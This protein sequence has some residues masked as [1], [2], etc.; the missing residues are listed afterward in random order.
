[1]GWN[2]FLEIPPCENGSWGIFYGSI[3]LKI[4]FFNSSSPPKPKK[5]GTGYCWF[6]GHVL[7]KVL[8]IAQRSGWA[9][10]IGWIHVPPDPRPPTSASISFRFKDGFMRSTQECSFDHWPQHAKS[11]GNRKKEENGQK[12]PSATFGW[13]SVSNTFKIALPKRGSKFFTPKGVL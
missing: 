12:G 1:M 13:L 8:T 10:C 5:I 11:T 9:F 3:N 4:V 7:W 2:R 6:L